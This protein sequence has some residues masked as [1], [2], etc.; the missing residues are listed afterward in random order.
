ME[1]CLPDMAGTGEI[2]Y[3]GRTNTSMLPCSLIL[4]YQ[5]PEEEKLDQNSAGPP[6][7]ALM[8]QAS[9]LNI[10]KREC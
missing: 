2:K 3:P 5:G 4:A 7:W 10:G 8:Q 6:R 9:P 1:E